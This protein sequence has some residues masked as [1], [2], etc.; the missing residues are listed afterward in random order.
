MAN[1]PSILKSIGLSDKETAVYLAL[2]ELGPS[3]VRRLAEKAKI[4]RGT[5]Y[6]M[7]TALRDLGLA[8][9]FH[10][11]T[12][13]YFVAEDPNRLLQVVRNRRQALDQS[14][15][16]LQEIIPDLQSLANR[17]GAKPVVKYY[18]GGKDIAG[19]LRDVLETVADLTP[20]EYVVY[21]AADIRQYL[22]S[23]FPT[24][25]E[26]RV[27]QGI[28]VKV[29]ALGAGGELHGH[30]ERK[31]LTREE[32]APTTKIIY[33]DKVSPLALSFAMPTCQPPSVLSSTPSGKSYD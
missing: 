30:D 27:K 21:S 14:S 10:K 32:R 3:P 8:S 22:Y 23:D 11:Q 4:N 31:W 20:K 1:I 2:L 12:H 16:D 7:L 26:S 18:E 9:Y 29:I 13:Q 28:N 15:T 25:N 24:F 19:I 5:T 17:A 6:D 33:G